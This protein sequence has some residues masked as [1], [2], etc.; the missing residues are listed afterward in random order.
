MPASP[1]IASADALP[2]AE[3]ADRSRSHGELGLPP[4]EP[5]RRGHP[6]RLPRGSASVQ[7]VRQTGVQTCRGSAGDH[8]VAVAAGRLQQRERGGQPDVVP[9][10]E[11]RWPVV[12]AWDKWSTS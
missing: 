4:H 8:G 6:R 2:L 11:R 10:V 12:G 9:G 5:L 7:P 1:S 3:L